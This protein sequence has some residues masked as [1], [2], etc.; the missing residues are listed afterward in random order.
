MESM[1]RFV[2]IDLGN[3]P[4]PDETTICKFRHLLEAHD[5][6][7]RIF[8]EVNAHLESRGMRLSEG[9][10]VDAT[11]INAPSSTKNR[12]KK[13]D[14]DMHST[15]KG[16]Q[17][18]FGW[19]DPR[20]CRQGHQ[21]GPQPCHYACQRARLESCWRTSS[22]RRKRSMGDSAYM[23]KTEE[24][25]GKAPGAAD[26][27]NRRSTRNRKL[28]EEETERNRMLSRTR[29][30][31]EHVFGVAKNIFGYRKVRY[32]GLVKNTNFIHVL[33]AL[34]NLYMVRRDLL[35]LPAGA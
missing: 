35:S 27:T 16:N 31:V 20:R 21:T 24:I 32:K 9:T 25:N 8:R 3:E 19:E 17:F 30:R 29:A 14:P 15:K 22:W 28:T 4:V 18:Y 7:E 34:S 6:G 33:F 10:I 5:L 23:G 13:R 1:R 26:N 12:E 11:I 2:G